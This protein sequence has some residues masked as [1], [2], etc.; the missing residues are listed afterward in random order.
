MNCVLNVCCF[1]VNGEW[2]EHGN[3]SS[4]FFF[5][6]EIV[7]S[8]NNSIDSDTVPRTIE[9]VYIKEE[10]IQSETDDEVHSC[11]GVFLDQQFR[12][13]YKN[14]KNFVKVMVKLFVCTL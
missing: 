6:Q 12:N 2:E 1:I 4:F 3:V 5:S 7:S 10:S 14:K 8:S 11:C 13:F 9:S